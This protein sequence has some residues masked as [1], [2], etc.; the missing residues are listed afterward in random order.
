M[1]YI[2]KPTISGSYPRWNGQSWTTIFP[3]RPPIDANHLYVWHLGEG[4]TTTGLD[5]LPDVGG[6]TL[7]RNAGT[8]TLETGYFLFD[9][10]QSAF[11]DQSTISG[12]TLFSAS[13]SP[14]AVSQPTTIEAIVLFP[15]ESV[16]AV[17]QYSPVARIYS[18]APNLNHDYQF[19]GYVVNAVAPGF[20]TI[21]N[22]SFPSFFQHAGAFGAGAGQVVPGIPTHMM[23]TWDP[24]ANTIKFFINGQLVSTSSDPNIAGNRSQVFAEVEIGFIPGSSIAD[25]R[26]SDVAR[27]QAYALA[28]TR[29][30][31]AL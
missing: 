29:A 4:C 21:R 10:Q 19:I 6:V 13:I 3:Q 7:N 12:V 16:G 8:A 22:N 20:A 9:T 2:G 5:I 30:M 11:A 15:G 26:I 23:S 24:G 1:T 18:G 31:R 17:A 28:A 14:I 27:D 25:V